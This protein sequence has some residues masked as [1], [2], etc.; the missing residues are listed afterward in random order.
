MSDSKFL[1]KKANLLRHFCFQQFTTSFSTSVSLIC[2]EIF[3]ELP[4][5]T[6]QSLISLNIF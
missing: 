5:K 1:I 4:E 2:L 3:K 6:T